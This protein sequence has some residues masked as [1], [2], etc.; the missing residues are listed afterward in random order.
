KNQIACSHKRY[1]GL[2]VSQV[3]SLIDKWYIITTFHKFVDRQIYDNT[4]TTL[5][6]K[7]YIERKFRNVFLHI[8]EAQKVRIES[9]ATGIGTKG[10]A[11]RAIRASRARSGRTQ[12]ELK[13]PDRMY[14]GILHLIEHAPGLKRMISTATPMYHSREELSRVGNLILMPQ[15]RMIEG[16]D[17]SDNEIRKMFNGVVSFVRQINR[18]VDLLDEGNLVAQV[19]SFQRLDRVETRAP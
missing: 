4:L 13:D 1:I 11:A 18:Y 17:Y 19:N 10:S 3:M 5:R 9:K 6:P 8:D 16:K 2:S 14:K 15:Q 12:Q 7:E